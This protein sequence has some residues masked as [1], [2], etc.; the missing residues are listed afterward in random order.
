MM[1]LN[2]LPWRNMPLAEAYRFGIDNGLGNEVSAIQTMDISLGP[3]YCSAI[4]RG[5]MVELLSDHQLFEGF[6]ES[7]W[8]HGHTKEGQ[9]LAGIYLE[10]KQHYQEMSEIS[11]IPVSDEAK[12]ESVERENKMALLYAIE[13]LFTILGSHPTK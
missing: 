7:R 13:A 2:V 11:K 6:K 9:K 4:R 3:L 10:A 12:R 8:Q 1:P 5:Y